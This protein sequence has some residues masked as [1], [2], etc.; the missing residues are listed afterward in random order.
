[1]VQC[2]AR[3]TSTC[4][5][6]KLWTGHHICTCRLKLLMDFLVVKGF[7]AF[8]QLPFLLKKANIVDYNLIL[9]ESFDNP[10]TMIE[11]IYL[12]IQY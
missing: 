12:F 7:L 3:I 11:L 4:P 10:K 6:F 8:L 9:V 2:C 1:M 5:G